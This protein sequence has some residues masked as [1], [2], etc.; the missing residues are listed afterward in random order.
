MPLIEL[1]RVIFIYYNVFKF[2]VPRSISF[3]GQ[4]HPQK[5]THTVAHRDSNGYSIG[6]QKNIIIIYF[7]IFIYLCSL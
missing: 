5:H 7:V 6:L 4:N 3:I 2:C 1:F